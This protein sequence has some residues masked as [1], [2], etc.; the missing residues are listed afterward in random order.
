MKTKP[1]FWTLLAGCLVGALL[2]ANAATEDDLLTPPREE[3]PFDNRQKP[4]ADS[5]LFAKYFK[6]KRV[7]PRLES[8]AG[9]GTSIC[10]PPPGTNAGQAAPEP[11][12]NVHADKNAELAFSRPA[13]TP[14]PEGSMIVKELLAT[15]KKSAESR[16]L[17]A[18]VKRDEGFDPA[19]G[20]WEFLVLR[21]LKQPIIVERGKIAHCHA[22]HEKAKAQDFVFRGYA[23]GKR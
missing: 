1:W 3:S 20:D 4:D 19:H 17:L 11:L 22:C 18:M 13:S 2:P 15:N 23:T 16:T 12:F 7:T 21:R 10:S 9:G 8:A 14:F 6:W 5:L